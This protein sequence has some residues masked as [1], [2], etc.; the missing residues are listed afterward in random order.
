M[1]CFLSKK[2]RSKREAFC[3]V[4]FLDRYPQLESDHRMFNLVV[5]VIRLSLPATMRNFTN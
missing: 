2:E 1:P 5:A 4:R 3:Q